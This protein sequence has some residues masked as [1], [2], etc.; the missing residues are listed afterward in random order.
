M[1]LK[2]YRKINNLSY[3]ALADQLGFSENKT[4]RICN[5]EERG[6]VRLVDAHKIIK[7]TKGQ[8]TWSDLLPIEGDC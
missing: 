3:R 4:F 6:C 2:N 5:D 8:V 7:V 1:K